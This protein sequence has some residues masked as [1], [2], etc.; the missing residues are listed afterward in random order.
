MYDSNHQYKGNCR[1]IE[2]KCREKGEQFP[3]LNLI[4]VSNEGKPEYTKKKRYTHPDIES[5]RRTDLSEM[6]LD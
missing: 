4:K 3:C 2:H 5:F 6:Q 1:L